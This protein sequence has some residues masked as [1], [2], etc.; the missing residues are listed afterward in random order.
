MYTND[1]IYTT[2]RMTGGLKRFKMLYESLL[3]KGF[4]VTLYC[5]ENNDTLKKY[6]PNA[7]SIN[8]D[9]K[10]VFLFPSIT[11]FLRNRKILKEIRKKKYDDVIVFDVPTAVGLCINRIKN[12]NLFL[13]QDLIEYRKI[14]LNDQHK[15]WLYKWIYLKFMLLCEYICCKNAKKIIIQCE[16][17]LNNLIN[18]HKFI[19]NKIKSKSYIQINNVN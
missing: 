11:I 2:S 14:I 9:E 13:R 5:G 6:N 19:R 16:Y 18:R 8:R 10:K 7:I 15:N 3:Q 1:K 17:D 4:D 12:I